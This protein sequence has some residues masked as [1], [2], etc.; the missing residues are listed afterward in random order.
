MTWTD[1]DWPDLSLRFPEPRPTSAPL[2]RPDVPVEVAE[3]VHRAEVTRGVVAPLCMLA[4]AALSCA[5]LIVYSAAAERTGRSPVATLLLLLAGVMVAFVAPAV[6]TLR[7]GPTWEQRQQHWRLQ[8]WETQRRAWLA[9]ER[10]AYIATLPP[11]LRESFCTLLDV[12]PAGQQTEPG[13]VAP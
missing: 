2:P 13:D 8:Q 3:R 9:R 5:G 7:I 10:A 11:H 6:A 1:L 12:T 4:G